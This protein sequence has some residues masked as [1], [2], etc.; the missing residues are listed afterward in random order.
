MRKSH[1]FFLTLAMGFG[2]SLLT[3]LHSQWAGQAGLGELQRR[4]ELVKQLDLT[5]LSLFTEARYT[6]HLSQSDL[7]TGFQDH[8]MALEHFPSG[9]LLLP[10]TG[11]GHLNANP[12]P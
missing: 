7:H 6:R 4:S 8:P 3:L 12:D 10:P 2:L 9:S 11:L 1:L 5:D